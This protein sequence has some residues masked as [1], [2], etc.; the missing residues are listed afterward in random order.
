MSK[1]AIILTDLMHIYNYRI[2]LCNS[3][4]I[5]VC[6][7][8][9]APTNHPRIAIIHPY[10]TLFVVANIW[11]ATI[12]PLLIHIINNIS[13][14]RS[15]P[16]TIRITRVIQININ[17]NQHQPTKPWHHPSPVWTGQ[18]P[19]LPGL[20]ARGPRCDLLGKRR[21]SKRLRRVPW[22]NVGQILSTIY[23]W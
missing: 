19:G 7:S 23:R 14:V 15:I 6:P 9:V 8:M 11:Y 4:S 20:T 17:I 18:F 2:Y 1:Y 5:W 12:N 22:V 13:Y 10:N 16:N 3:M 21:L